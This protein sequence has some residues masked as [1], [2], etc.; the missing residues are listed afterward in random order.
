MAKNNDD[1]SQDGK[2]YQDDLAKQRAKVKADEPPAPEPAAGAT[3]EQHEDAAA[4]DAEAAA[5]AD[6]EAAQEED[7]GQ[8]A[9]EVPSSGGKRITL[10][11]AI[12]RGVPIE[13]RVVMTSKSIAN[14]KG[15][16]LDPSDTDGLLLVP[17]LVE[18]HRPTYLRDG[19]GEIKKV[20]VYTTIKPK[21]VVNAQSEA[22]ETLLGIATPLAA[23]QALRKQGVTDKDIEREFRA[24]LEHVEADAA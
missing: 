11:T 16:L 4:A 8:F 24:A 21:H 22:G 18:S 13:H 14:P 12:P 15:G 9:F 2:Q 6:A 5:A 1:I 20:I 23:V 10:G 17:Y 19:D 7:D 3:V